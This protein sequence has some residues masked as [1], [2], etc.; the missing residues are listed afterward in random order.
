MTKLLNVG[1]SPGSSTGSRRI[2]SYSVSARYAPPQVGGLVDLGGHTN[3][4][5]SIEGPLIGLP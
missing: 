1:T 5:P 4:P 3:N 2:G